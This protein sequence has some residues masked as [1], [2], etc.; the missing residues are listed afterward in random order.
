MMIYPFEF[1]FGTLYVDWAPVFWSN[2]NSQILRSGQVSRVYKYSKLSM[3]SVLPVVQNTDEE[4]QATP[5]PPPVIE[6]GLGYFR[7]RF[8]DRAS[9]VS[10]GTVRSAGPLLLEKSQSIISAASVTNT[11]SQAFEYE[12]GVRR[13]TGEDMRCGELKIRPRKLLL[14][15][16]QSGVL[17]L[18]IDNPFVKD[19]ND[20]ISETQ[21][22][23]TSCNLDLFALNADEKGTISANA[24]SLQLSVPHPE[25]NE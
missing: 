12:L 7:S 15:R 23:F 22:N 18:V 11:R 21:F 8:R 9:G 16:S 25:E 20:T 5:S 13:I 2:S 19:T 17:S 10:S 14:G 4:E 6:R 1:A 24:I 3:S